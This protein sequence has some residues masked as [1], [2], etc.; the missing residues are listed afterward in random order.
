M[1]INLDLCLNHW[2]ASYAHCPKYLYS[3]HNTLVK[4]LYNPNQFKDLQF[5]II[6]LCTHLFV[7]QP[8]CT[9]T[10]IP[11]RI[12]IYSYTSPYPHL[13]VYQPVCTF[14]RIPARKHI[15]SYTSPYTHLLVYQPVN[16]FTRILARIHIYLYTSPYNV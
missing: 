1:L 16:T 6:F 14:T 2:Q 11:A 13:L 5:Y 12:H 3:I 8:V 4:S 7:Y 15:Y 9:F 10:R